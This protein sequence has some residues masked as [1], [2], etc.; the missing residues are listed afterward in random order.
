VYSP[1]G[2]KLTV[3]NVAKNE[4]VHVRVFGVSRAGRRGSPAKASLKGPHKKHKKKHH[5][6]KHHHHP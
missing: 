4:G 6:K 5:K 3:P 1:T 2:L